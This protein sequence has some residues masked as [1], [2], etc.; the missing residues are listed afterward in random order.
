MANCPHTLKGLTDQHQ[1]L[2]DST[3]RQKKLHYTIG[4]V[5]VPGPVPNYVS[6][7]FAIDFGGSKTG[8]LKVSVAYLLR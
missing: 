2:F 8:P 7:S 4:G 5:K 6:G 3:P 1:T